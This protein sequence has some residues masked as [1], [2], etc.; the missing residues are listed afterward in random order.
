METMQQDNKTRFA[1]S[2]RDA[3]E[4]ILNFLATEDISECAKAES[5]AKDA[6]AHQP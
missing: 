5:A 4:H 6:A 1:S 2:C 3:L